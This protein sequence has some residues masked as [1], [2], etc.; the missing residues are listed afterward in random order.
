MWLHNSGF[1]QRD[2]RWTASSSRVPTTDARLPLAACSLCDQTRFGIMTASHGS[3]SWHRPCGRLHYGLHTVIALAIQ[4]PLLSNCICIAIIGGRLR[5]C[6]DVGDGFSVNVPRSC[7]W[8]NQRES[9]KARD[10]QRIQPRF[11]GKNP[12]PTAAQ[13]LKAIA[14]ISILQLLCK[15]KPLA[16]R[17]H[18]PLSRP[19]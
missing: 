18:S 13:P 7:G 15:C 19:S 4:S 12:R 16:T 8:Q 5:Q 14:G 1:L 17:I 11:A 9:R 3:A 10:F 6:Q 2:R